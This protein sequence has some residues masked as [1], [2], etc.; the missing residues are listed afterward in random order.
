M[1]HGIV[2]VRTNLALTR[3]DTAD[4]GEHLVNCVILF[5]RSLEYTATKVLRL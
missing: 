1:I 4:L 2:H 3:G 5:R